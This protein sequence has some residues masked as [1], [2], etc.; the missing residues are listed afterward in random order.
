MSQK[1]KQRGAWKTLFG[2]LPGKFTNLK[3]FRAL[4]TFLPS[5][6]LVLCGCEQGV[7]CLLVSG[8]NERE[9]AA[10][11]YYV[12]FCFPFLFFV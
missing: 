1:W 6:F 3:M 7:N 8:E 10:H 4:V 5:L 11:F 9:I 12:F 2:Y